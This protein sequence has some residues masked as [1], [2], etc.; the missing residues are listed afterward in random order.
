MW[1]KISELLWIVGGI[2]INDILGWLLAAA[3]GYFIYRVIDNMQTSMERHVVLKDVENKF[4]DIYNS[5]IA[6]ACNNENNAS[7]EQ[8]MVRSVLH[9]D[10]AWNVVLSDTPEG[11]KKFGNV[12]VITDNQRYIQIRNGM[13]TGVDAVYHNE[14][15]STQALHEILLHCRRIEKMYKDNVI[16]RIDLADMFREIIPLGIGGRIEFFNAY[17]S[18]YDTDCMGYLVMQTVVSCEKYYNTDAVRK[19][20]KYYNAHAEIHE[21]FEKSKRIRMIGDCLLVK[22][23]RRICNKYADSI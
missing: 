18:K 6:K 8:V 7:L 23:F 21:F 9:D 19:F 22:R 5:A 13:G 16:K 1:S 11:G 12:Q 3:G 10:G 17:Y 20:V 4:S 14:W 2:G 15:I